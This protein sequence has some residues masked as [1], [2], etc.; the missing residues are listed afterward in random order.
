VVLH[1]PEVAGWDVAFFESGGPF[2]GL[3]LLYLPKLVENGV[4]GSSPQGLLDGIMLTVVR[5]VLPLG[6]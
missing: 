2:E 1:D 5:G 3:P 4:L 6:E